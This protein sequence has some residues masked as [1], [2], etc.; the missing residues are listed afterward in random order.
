MD[1]WC[2][3]IALCN[4]VN[5]LK[6]YPSEDDSGGEALEWKLL[7]PLERSLAA[8]DNDASDEPYEVDDDA[9]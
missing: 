9:N 8:D 5:G 6:R 2:T 7:F 1:A 3:S 4:A